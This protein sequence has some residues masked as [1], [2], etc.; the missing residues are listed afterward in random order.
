ME[1]SRVRT[2]EEEE[3][4]E[5]DWSGGSDDDG[6][7]DFSVAVDSS[8]GRASTKMASA[9]TGRTGLMDWTR[10]TSTIQKVKNVAWRSLLFLVIQNR[11]GEWRASS[12]FS[13]N[14]QSGLLSS[15]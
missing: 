14:Y 8:S 1:W 2:E 10:L 7:G 4:E 11:R 6:Y 15:S 3:E 13:F 12:T 5:E 9:A